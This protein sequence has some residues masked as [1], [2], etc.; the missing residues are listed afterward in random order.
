MITPIERGDSL[1]YELRHAGVKGMKWGVRNDKKPTGKAVANI[2]QRRNTTTITARTDD[3]KAKLRVKRDRGAKLV[4]KSQNTKIKVLVSNTASM[5][6]GALWVAS[7]L[8]PGMPVLN[9]IAAAANIVGL[10]TANK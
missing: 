4:A 5:A 6:S 8:V 10:A 2:R 3:Q 1:E 7:A 9:T